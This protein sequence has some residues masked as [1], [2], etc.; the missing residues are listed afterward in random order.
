MASYADFVREELLELAVKRPCCKKALVC[1]LLLNATVSDGKIIACY[2]HGGT[3][4]FA[5]KELRRQFG[6]LPVAEI[7]LAHGHTK[8]RLALASAVAEK[9]LQKMGGSDPSEE[10]G[11]ECENCR[12][13]FLRGAFLSCGTMNDPH[14]S[15]HLEFLLQDAGRADWLKNALS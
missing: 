3:A 12:S 13:A 6:K 15:T 11:A 8:H 7:C 10:G 2:R 4:E 5:A 1:G 9:L 14:K